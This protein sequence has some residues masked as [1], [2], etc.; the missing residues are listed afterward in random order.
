VA[1]LGVKDLVV[2]RT[3]EVTLVV[4]RSRSHEVRRLLR[5]LEE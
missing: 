2:V 1:V 4:P 3:D 5:A